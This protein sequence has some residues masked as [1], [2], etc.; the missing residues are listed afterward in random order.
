MRRERDAQL[1]ATHGWH[2]LELNPEF[3]DPAAP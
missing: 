3:V 1:E 2:C